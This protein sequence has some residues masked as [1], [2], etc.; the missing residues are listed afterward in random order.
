MIIVSQDKKAII[1]FKN[2]TEI[3]ISTDEISANQDNE[4]ENY[5]LRSESVCGLYEDLGTYDT[6]E[7]AKEVLQEI[8]K[9]YRK[10]RIAE[11]D[12][13]TNVLRETAVFE[14]PKEQGD[15]YGR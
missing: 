12:G 3:Y 8:I 2:L 4:K 6:E 11:C 10:Y 1:N 14:M 7:R 5:Y 15:L 9:A 13:Y